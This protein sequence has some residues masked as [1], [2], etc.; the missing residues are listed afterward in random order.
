MA[1]AP[2]EITAFLDEPHIA[3]MATVRPDGRPHAVPIWYEYDAGEIVFHMGP[4]SVRYRNLLNNKYAALCIDTRIPP[5]KAVILEGEVELQEGQD[6]ERTA[7]MA[8]H[9]L[10]ERVGRRY[11]ESMKGARV[12][13]GRLRPQRTISWDYGKRD[14]P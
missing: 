3:V 13:I 10:G 14:D 5:Y 8:V 6:D 11:A 7:R 4:A 12:I 9:Y 1:I 2:E